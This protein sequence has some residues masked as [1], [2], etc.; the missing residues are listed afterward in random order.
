VVEIYETEDGESPFQ[1]WLKS[2]RGSQAHG[3]VLARLK[4]VERGNFGDFHYLDDGV[5]ELR[6]MTRSGPRVYY[7]EDRIRNEN[8]GDEQ[9]RVMVLWGGLKGSQQRDI[10]TAKKFWR[11]HNAKAGS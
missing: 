4:N 11:D 7:G 8:T 10:E 5:S 9:L 2:I 3:K 6:F 1:D